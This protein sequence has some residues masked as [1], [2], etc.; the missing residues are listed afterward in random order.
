LAN[1]RYEIAPRLVVYGDGV[2]ADAYINTT[3]YNGDTK[4]IKSISVSNPGIGYTDSW[5]A[6]EPAGVTT[7]GQELPTFRSMRS[8]VGGHGS[9][10]V[11][12]LQCNN[13]LI[14][15]NAD[16]TEDD[17]FIIDTELYQYG[18]LKNP[19]LNDT[20]AAYLDS[21]GKPFRVAGKNTNISRY[22]DVVS[23]TESTF[24]PEN[25]FV[26]GN[27]VIGVSTKTTALIESWGPALT[28]RHGLLKIK[29]V[30]GTFFAPN[31]SLGLGEELAQISVIENDWTVHHSGLARVSGF[32]EV[33]QAETPAF[34]CTHVLEVRQGVTPLTETSFTVGV[35]VT[36]GNSSTG[37]IEQPTGMC[38]SW[39]PSNNGATGELVVNDVKG[40]LR[41]DDYIGSES[42]NS[43]SSRINS[44]DNPELLFNSGEII[45][46]QNIRPIS[47]GAEQRE[48]YQLLF[49]F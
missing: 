49:G 24:L 23:A 48:Q 38:V 46:L 27:Y 22:L 25:L 3:D 13:V 2:S 18:I 45:Y 6:L 19:I 20:D 40:T 17:K 30:N 7:E 21:S 36:G 26:P 37:G 8:P 5:F 9:D 35:G 16:K 29:N 15:V 31:D 32:D 10:A 14:V 41:V 44:V 34:R 12:E 28:T 43:T 33:I 1:S 11:N 39:V 4:T 42:Y 47:R